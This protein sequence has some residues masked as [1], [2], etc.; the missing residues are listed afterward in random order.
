V[1]GPR[2]ELFAGSRLA[3]DQDAGVC[4]GHDRDQAQGGPQGGARSDDV[5]EL[6]AS[7]LLEIASLGRLLVPILDRLSV[8]Q[9]VLNRDGHLTGHLFQKGDIVIGKG[10]LRPLEG[11]ENADHA[12]SAD[13]REIAAR[14]QTFRHDPLIEAATYAVAEAVGV[15]SHVLEVIEVLSLAGPERFAADRAMD[16]YERPVAEGASGRG[17]VQ[18]RHAQLP[19]VRIRKEQRAKV[20]ARYA[21]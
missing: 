7:L 6:G 15:V 21:Q 19:T 11:G 8:V 20:T 2:D 10:P 17:V 9:R 1:D 18:S 3:Q 14:L 16:G 12:V 5:P 4:G 13:E